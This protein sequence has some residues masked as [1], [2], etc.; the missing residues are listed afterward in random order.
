MYEYTHVHSIYEQNDVKPFLQE[1][2]VRII[3]E[4]I[5]FLAFL[6]SFLS[7]LGNVRG[8]SAGHWLSM[9]A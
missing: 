2:A 7:L 1:R 5:T 9:K 6:E 4:K 3:L 8:W